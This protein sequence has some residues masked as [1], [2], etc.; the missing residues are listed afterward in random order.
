MN[1]RWHKPWGDLKATPGRF[2]MMVLAMAI[3]VAALTAMLF[4]YVVLTVR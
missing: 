3:S 4:S 2:V 1:T